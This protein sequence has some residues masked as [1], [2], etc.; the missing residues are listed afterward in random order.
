MDIKAWLLLGVILVALAVTGY[1]PL[2]VV[3]VFGAVWLA[4][5]GY[6]SRRRTKE[7]E[8]QEQQL[9]A[10]EAPELLGMDFV[11]RTTF[12][13]KAADEFAATA[14]SEDKQRCI[15]EVQKT[16]AAFEAQKKIMPAW[17]IHAIMRT[18]QSEAVNSPGNRAS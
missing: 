5:S 8:D 3:L 11:T 12:M 7:E 10:Q 17:L 2:W 18:I 1:V 14:S 16:K 9:I 15:D 13:L 4:Y 6:L